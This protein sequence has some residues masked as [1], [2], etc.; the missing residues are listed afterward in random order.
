[1]KILHSN[2]SIMKT[3]IYNLTSLTENTGSILS[4]TCVEFDMAVSAPLVFKQTA[5]E[6]TFER[7]LVAVDLLMALQVAQ[8]AE[9]D[10]E[11]EDDEQSFTQSH[12]K[13][14]NLLFQLDKIEHHRQNM[15]T[16]TW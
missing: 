3:L 5:T 15:Q 4:C 13:I 8:T 12:I 7:Q 14:D 6:G 1:M 16:V 10:Q 9:E 2:Y 11:E